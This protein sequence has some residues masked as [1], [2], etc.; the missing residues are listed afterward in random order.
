MTLGWILEG[1]RDR[2]LAARDPVPAPMQTLPLFQCPFCKASFRDRAQLTGHIDGFHVTRRPFMLIG[3]SEPGSEDV[4]RTTVV[5]KSVEIFNCTDLELAIDG[6]VFQSGQQER[7]AERLT[8]LRRAIVQLRL[9]NKGDR[10]GQPVT[11]EYRLKILAPDERSLAKIDQ[12]F[13]AQLGVEAVNMERVGLF[14]EATRDS[15]ACEYA[16]ALADYVRAVLLKDGDPATGVSNRLHHYH[17]VQNR[18]LLVLQSFDR[19]LARLLCGLICFS[20]NDFSGSYEPTGFDNLDL[21]Y[22]L[23]RPLARDK[24]GSVTDRK[25]HAARRTSVFVCPVDVGID[26]VARLAQ[27]ATELSRWGS[28]AEERFS[29]LANQASIDSFDGAKIRALWGATAIRLG[30]VASAVR[31][32]RLLDGDPTFGRWATDKLARIDT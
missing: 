11:Q 28:A 19:P 15:A 25:S 27:Q 10:L 17:E 4:I 8:S 29:S 18:A 5:A 7:L 2:F 30:A 9:R 23:L 1:D 31:A 3:G 12:L 24:A 20:L 14:Y 16:E 13:L 26:T 32:L 22:S 21:A 6:D